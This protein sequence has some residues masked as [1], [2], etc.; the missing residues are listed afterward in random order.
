MLLYNKASSRERRPAFM[1]NQI[2]PFV[3]NLHVG[4]P[5]RQT[6][7]FY[8]AAFQFEPGWLM[9][10]NLEREAKCLVSQTAV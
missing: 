2:I 10:G 6:A 4:Q 3:G 1:H 9:R 7:L 8:G 5:I